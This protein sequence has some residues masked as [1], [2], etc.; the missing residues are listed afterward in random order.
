MNRHFF[1]DSLAKRDQE[2]FDLIN[3]EGTRQNNSIE[4]IASENIV[5]KAVLEAMGSVLTNKY[6]EGY[7]GRRYYNGCEYV[8]GIERLAISRIKELFNCSYANV[9]SHSGSQANAAVFNAF[10][11]PGDVIMGMDLNAGG[12]LTHGSKASQSGKWFEAVPYYV[13]KEDGLI[14]YDALHDIAVAC[15]PKLIIAGSSA[16]SRF[17][18]FEFFRKVA[19][20]VGAMLLA[21]IAHYSG[22]V[23][24][25]LYPSPMQYADVVTS[26]THK[27][28]RGARGGII[29]SNHKDIIK[30]INSSVFPGLQG[31]PLMNMIAGKAVA[32]KEAL[33]DDFKEYCKQIISNAKALAIRL[34]EYGFDIVTNGTDTHL[35]LVDLTSKNISGAEAADKLEL[36]GIT[37]NK[38]SVPFDKRSITETSGIRLGTAFVTTRGFK[39]ED[40]KQIADI[41]NN[42]ILAQDNQL[43][44]IKNEVISLC[45]K[46]P[47]Y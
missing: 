47:L 4:L 44:V 30:K 19:D 43:T 42:T 16:Y 20:K 14:D 11:T 31:G 40:C 7:P 34:Q 29:L 46:F 39:E 37:C 21:D 1:T 45:R 18:D 9:Q 32:F 24:T 33:Q 22:L 35:V 17:I 36:V 6:A 8:D 23:V 15:K 5:S 3:N 10:L 13:N 2:I 12:H 41:I 25:N 38:N 28:L 26:T 27:T